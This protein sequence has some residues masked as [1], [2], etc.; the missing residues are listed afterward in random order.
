MSARLIAVGVGPG[1][2]ELVTLKGARLIRESDIVI[3]PVGDSSDSS[4]AL[5]IVEGLIDPKRQQV[6]TQV[7][8]MKKDPAQ[9][10]ETWRQAAGE[11]AEMVDAGKSVAFVTLGDPVVFSTFLHLYRMLKRYHPQVDVEIVP[12]VSSINAAGALAQRPLGL[13]EDR[14]AVLPAT[15]AEEDLER[16]LNEFETVVLMK[17]HRS[18]FRIKALLERVGRKESA[19]YVKRAG[20][21]GE[22]VFDDLDQVSEEVLDY[23]SLIIVS[24]A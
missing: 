12:G 16:A 3:T 7:Y 5:S 2:P 4:I 19:V 24:K 9:L 8:P 11:V 17:V 22:A 23:L 15:A 14:L 21:P 10:E 6:V 20:L 1:D 18:F 13:Y